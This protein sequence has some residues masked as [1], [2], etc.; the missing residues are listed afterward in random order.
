MALT[1]ATIV[2][3]LGG[4]VGGDAA[5]LAR[6]GAVGKA[7]EPWG[8]VRASRV[9]RTAPLGPAQPDFLNAALAIEAEDGLVASELLR[10]VQALEQTYGRRRAA[11]TRNGPRPI[12]LDVLLWGDRSFD[13]GGG[14]L[15]VPHPRLAKRRFALAPVVDLLGAGARHPSEGRTFGEL[16]AAVRDQRVEVT[17]YTIDGAVLTVATDG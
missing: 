1:A 10:Q 11:E 13:F 2:L 7:F 6:F 8:T 12:D 5:V 9:Y 16:L 3:G 4:N 15:I 14:K 17:S